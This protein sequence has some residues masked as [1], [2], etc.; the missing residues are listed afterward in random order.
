MTYLFYNV[1]EKILTK[2]ISKLTKEKQYFE[3]SPRTNNSWELC[4]E[5]HSQ[6]YLE[7]FSIELKH[8][9]ELYKNV[10]P[11]DGSFDLWS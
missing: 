10:I 2:V 6:Q 8:A 1:D 7:Q 11:A 3:A 5:A 4:V 9:R